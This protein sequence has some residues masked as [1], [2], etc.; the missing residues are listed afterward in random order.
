MFYSPDGWGCWLLCW[1]RFHCSDR[2]PAWPTA[3]SPWPCRRRRRSWRWPGDRRGSCKHGSPP[4]TSLQTPNTCNSLVSRLIT[5]WRVKQANL[6]TLVWK[7]SVLM[8]HFDSLPLLRLC[9]LGS[10]PRLKQMTIR[11]KLIFINIF[12]LKIS[13]VELKSY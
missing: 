8:E 1:S 7:L 6:P 13:Q 12:I 10:K 2:F 11:K 4:C 9:F 3:S 5:W